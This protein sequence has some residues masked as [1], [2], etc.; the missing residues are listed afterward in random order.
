MIGKLLPTL[1]W[2]TMRE[3]E[4][5]SPV[6]AYDDASTSTS[7]VSSEPTVST[8][9]DIQSDINFSISSSDSK[10]EDYIDFT[11][12]DCILKREPVDNHVEINNFCSENINA[13]TTDNIICV[14]NDINPIEFEENNETNH[15]TQ[16][17][18][19][20]KKDFVLMIKIMIDQSFKIR[21]PTT[22]LIKNL[23]VSLGIPFNPKW[24][25]KD[26]NKIGVR[27]T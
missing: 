18:S 22:F 25:Y 4:A 17:K 9:N 21:M 19:F 5:A 2:T 8:Y 3:C 7:N 26:G 15:D 27:L 12:H 6:I 1:T 14:S 10:D 24:Y 13:K 11:I 23:Y 16:V 20:A